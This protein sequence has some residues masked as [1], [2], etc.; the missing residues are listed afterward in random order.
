MGRDRVS[1]IPA[2]TIR[3]AEPG[4]QGYVTSTWARS[5][6]RT[7]AFR[8]IPA[9]RYQHTVPREIDQILDRADTRVLVADAGHDRLLGWICATPIPPSVLTLHYVYVRQ[10]HAETPLRRHGIGRALVAAAK[11]AGGLRTPSSIVYTY[12]GPDERALLATQMGTYLP[13]G[14]FLL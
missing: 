12:R 5:L 1:Q 13:V 11:D 8:R 2:Y 4:D 6:K 7:V 9:D 14:R 10:E 3:P